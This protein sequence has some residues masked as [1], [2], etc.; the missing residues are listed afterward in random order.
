[1]TKEVQT[2]RPIISRLAADAKDGRL[3][4]REFISL[5]SV[6]GASAATAYGL[7][8][9]ATPASAQSTTPQRGGVLRLAA[10]VKPIVDP[11]VFDWPEMGNLARQFCEGL[12][13]WDYDFTFRPMLLESW[14]I[15][16]DARTYVLNVRSGVTW[17]NGDT[18]DVDDVIFN[19]TRWCDRTVEGNSMASRMASLIDSETDK[20]ADGV[21]EKIDDYTLQLNL[22]QPDITLIPGMSD[23]PALLVHRNFDTDGANLADSPIGTGP[24]ELESIEI[25]I[26]ASVV[27]RKDGN[28]WGGEAY[29]DGA[30]FIDYG[31]D[32][33]TMAA[34]FESDEVDAN[35]QTSSDFIEVLDSI[36]LTHK[37]QAT[38]STIVLRMNVTQP[39]FTDKRVRNAV[40]LGVDNSIVLELAGVKNGIVA[41]NHHVGPM[42]PEYVELPKVS[43]DPAAA[44][45]LMAEAGAQDT[46]IDLISVDADWQSV[47]GDAV[48]GQLRDAGFKVKRTLL[49]GA[50]FWNDW[51]KYPFSATDWGP[52]PL[53]VQVLA[54]AYR[55]GEAWNESAFSDPEFDAVL[56]EA[57][58]IADAEAR[59]V[60]MQRLEEILRDSG[61]IIQPFWRGFS[62]H[63]VEKVQGMRR[64][65]TRD[66]ELTSVWLES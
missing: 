56:D 30:E 21:L 9:T 48:A 44:M 50:T 10:N 63:H 14:E 4:R 31:T 58:G 15:S 35:D 18:F 38:A 42:H 49:P 45:A 13:F 6:Y 57:M 27:R 16:D 32:P 12:V 8:G 64:H 65:Q 17:N 41:E 47:T 23:F 51:T 25:G 11:R 7:L 3:S 34:A 2:T 46:E 55:S 26:R 37:S 19:I 54:L 20:I 33:S 40:Q 62:L 29:L 66:I 61:V 52:R 22:P 43:R 24:F 28:W 39:P 53:G 1:M 5:A 36:G 59:K 60:P